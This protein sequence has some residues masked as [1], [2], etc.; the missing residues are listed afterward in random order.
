MGAC[1]TKPAAKEGEE[2]LPAEEEAVKNKDK[3]VAAVTAAAEAESGQQSLSTLL[4]REI[5][6]E[7]KE[8]IAPE[9]P[10]TAEA[11]SAEPA[12]TKVVVVEPAKANDDKKPAEM[13]TEPPKEKAGGSDDKKEKPPPSPTLPSP[14]RRGQTLNSPSLIH[15]RSLERCLHVALRCVR[16]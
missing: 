14:R 7:V 9:E 13:P 10:A 2:P 11:K 8:T 3:E 5:E 6:V 16:A 15:Q 12:A 4:S 1:A